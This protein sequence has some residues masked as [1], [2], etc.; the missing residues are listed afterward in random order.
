MVKLFVGKKGSG[1]TKQ[2]IEM[3]ND[4]IEHAHGS[5]V[6]INKDSRIIYELSYKMRVICMQ[7]FPHITN[8]D[9]YIGFL[10]GILSS[11]H[12]IEKIFL[13][14]VMKHRDFTPEVL[15]SFL[16]KLSDMSNDYGIEFVVSVSAELEELVGVNFDSM[17]VL[18]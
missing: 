8:E 11:D 5:I 12:D 10:F 9:E 16:N 14:G 18:N 13:D 15:P 2:M 3:A 4:A 6:F 1:K 7:D 17:E